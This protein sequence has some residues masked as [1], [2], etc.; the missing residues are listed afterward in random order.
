MQPRHRTLTGWFFTVTC[1][2][3]CPCHLV[4]TLPLAAA[5][6]GGTALGGWIAT[7]EGAIA[8]GATLYFVGA[9]ALGATLLLT[10]ASRQVGD[11]AGADGEVASAAPCCSPDSDSSMQTGRATE[12]A[13]SN[14]TEERLGVR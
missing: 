4:V 3:A 7:H 5:L 14:T 10:R 12:D 9:L 1:F 2:L 8:L 11:T 6:L 13:A